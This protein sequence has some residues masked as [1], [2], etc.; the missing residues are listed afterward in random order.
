MA[1]VTEVEVQHAVTLLDGDRA[2][3]AVQVANKIALH[4]AEQ[5]FARLNDAAVST[6]ELDQTFKS[7]GDLSTRVDATGLSLP[8]KSI[9]S[10]SLQAAQ[11][12]AVDFMNININA[13][14]ASTL[15]DDVDAELTLGITRPDTIRSSST[16]GS[17]AKTSIVFGSGIRKIF[18]K[19]QGNAVARLLS[20]TAVV[21]YAVLEVF[22]NAVQ[23]SLDIGVQGVVQIVLQRADDFLQGS[24]R[25]SLAFLV[26]DAL[27]NL[28]DHEGSVG[29]HAE[30]LVEHRVVGFCPI[31]CFVCH[32]CLLY[33]KVRK[34]LK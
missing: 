17:R 4:S 32:F 24:K 26:L 5:A 23:L 14:S 7:L 18:M 9:V 6:E 21:V 25:V 12:F 22:A 20:H 19:S 30:R 1:L 2:L 34:K 10:S 33:I 28:T 16:S 27:L 11:I 3:A 29:Q 13:A 31:D 15:I 8:L